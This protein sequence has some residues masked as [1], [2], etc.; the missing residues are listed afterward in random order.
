MENEKVFAMSFAKVYPMLIAKAERKGRTKDE[1]LTVTN[2][3][4]GYLIEEIET[5]L[6]SD[7][8]Y[9]DFFRKAPFMNPERKLIK[10]SV[11]GVKVEL[12]DD[13][14]MQD[15]RYLDKLVDELAKG[16]GIEKILRNL[17]R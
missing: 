10:G 13:P 4:T 11:C 8:T 16:K 7:I 9:G 1:V 15:I 3:L 6:K 2:W 17:E 14:L 5:M 12:I